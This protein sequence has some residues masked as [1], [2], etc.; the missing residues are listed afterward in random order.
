VFDPSRTYH[1]RAVATQ[2]LARIVDEVSIRPLYASVAA[3]NVGSIR[4]LDKG[5]F[6]RDRGQEAKAP[7]SED[8]IEEFIFVLNA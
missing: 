6:R 8:S 3:H 1:G 5:G 7:A 4:V 2:P